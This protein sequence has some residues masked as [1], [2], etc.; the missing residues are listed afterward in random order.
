M[1]KQINRLRRARVDIKIG[2]VLITQWHNSDV[3]HQG[4]QLL[5]SMGVPVYT[6][7]IRRTD[8]V[9]ESTFDREPIV[10]YSP[11]SA[12]SIDYRRWVWEF[13]AAVGDSPFGLAGEG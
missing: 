9:P 4:E 5:R 12:A 3:V 8:K 6:Q 11:N 2:G 1:T 7:T 13:M 10:K